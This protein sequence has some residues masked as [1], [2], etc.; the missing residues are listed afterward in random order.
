MIDQPLNVDPYNYS[1]YWTIP[2]ESIFNN[3]TFNNN[4]VE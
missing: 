3:S 1:T 4:V 2:Q